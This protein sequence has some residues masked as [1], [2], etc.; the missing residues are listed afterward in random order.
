[1]LEKNKF[2]PK[3]GMRA[4]ITFIDG[5]R[6]DGDLFLSQDQR[7]LDLFNDERPFVPLEDVSG[8][9]R[10]ISKTAIMQ[11]RPLNP[12]RTIAEATATD[13]PAVRRRRLT[14]IET[15]DG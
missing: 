6:V 11:V 14:V 1:M 15:T 10:L 2:R 8:R 7:V 4:E 13:A 3:F 5:S 12:D 9:V